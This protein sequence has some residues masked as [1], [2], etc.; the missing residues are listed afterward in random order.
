MEWEQVAGALLISVVT[1]A[2]AG[3]I[4]AQKTIAAIIVHIDY[5]RSS[6]ERQ[7]KAIERAHSR[8]DDIERSA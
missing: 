6:V 4:G 5:L 3:Q 8:I 7:E 2:V 1:G